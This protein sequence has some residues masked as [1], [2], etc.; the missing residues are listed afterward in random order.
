MSEQTFYGQQHLTTDDEGGFNSLSFLVSQGLAKLNTSTLVKVL[1]TDAS[2]TAAVGYVD[3]MPLVHQQTGDDQSVPHGTI[4]GVPYLRLQGGTN[5]V[6]VDPVVGDTGFCLFA[7]RD[8][9]AVKANHGPANPGSRRRFDFA[10]AMY[11]GGWI[12]KAPKNYI[13]IKDDSIEIYATSSPINITTADKINN[14]ASDSVNSNAP[15]IK[16]TG[17]AKVTVIAP[18]IDLTA[19]ATVKVTAPSI[20]LN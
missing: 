9:S 10:D 2:G 13:Q 11:I 5:A 18:E 20:T 14:V 6:I 16:L 19:S 1:R 8:I 7:D 15:E 12:S 17:S 3:V 4:Y